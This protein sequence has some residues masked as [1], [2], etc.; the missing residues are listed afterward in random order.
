MIFSRPLPFESVV[1]RSQSKFRMAVS[2]Q[3]HGR[4]TTTCLRWM[5]AQRI[6]ISCTCISVTVCVPERCFRVIRLEI[7]LWWHCT[8][9]TNP[10]CS[11][12]TIAWLSTRNH[13]PLHNRNDI[14][15][16]SMP[17]RRSLGRKKKTR[18]Q[19]CKT[20][21]CAKYV[22]QTISKHLGSHL[23]R[24]AAQNCKRWGG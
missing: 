14:Y 5:N 17:F 3:S 18:T 10:Y 11:W 8:C 1:L 19:L 4:W 15:F 9:D 16:T 6:L 22:A 20:M 23:V 2:W 7:Y 21:V 13:L 24:R 12:P